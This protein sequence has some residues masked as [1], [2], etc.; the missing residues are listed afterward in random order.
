MRLDGQ[1][2]WLS[3]SYQ[4]CRSASFTTRKEKTSSSAYPNSLRVSTASVKALREMLGE[5][6][7]VVVYRRM[8]AGIAMQHDGDECAHFEDNV[9]LEVLMS[10][11]FFVIKYLIGKVWR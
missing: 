10:P 5:E 4:R 9:D 7:F 11:D 3:R 6:R 1:K 2:A 8:F